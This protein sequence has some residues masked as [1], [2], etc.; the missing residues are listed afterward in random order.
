M[1]K[2]TASKQTTTA[3]QVYDEELAKI[4]AQASKTEDSAA[5]GSFFSVRGGVLTFDNTP[6]PNNC[7]GV[8]ILHSILENVYYP[9]KFDPEA[10][11]APSCFAFGTENADLSPHELATDPQNKTCAGCP[12]NE[13][14]TA[15]VG[16]GKACRNTRR[17]ALIPAG[18]FDKAGREFT[19]FDDPEHFRTAQIAFLKL[20][21]TSVK[22]Y[23]T[24]VKQLAGTLKR[25]PC[26]VFTKITVVPDAKT[27]FKVLFEPQG[28]VTNDLL[29]VVMK[30]F[31]EAKAII[32]F[33]Y[34][35]MEDALSSSRPASR[36]KKPQPKAGK[37]TA[38]GPKRG[39]RF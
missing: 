6:M 8:I 9:G 24:F 12:N 25:P 27:Q 20:P 7:I 39:R 35:P 32:D 10:P 16:R 33:P 11:Q 36:A 30:R 1:A 31:E 28:L 37:K 21:V 18:Q 26:G 17:L 22:G 34:Q 19:P 5:G 4:A 14:G 13:W 23:A 38:A 15:D 2:R 29:S 3:L